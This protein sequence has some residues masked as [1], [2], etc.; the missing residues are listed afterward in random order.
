VHSSVTATAM[1]YRVTRTIPC[2]VV[3]F[4]PIIFPASPVAAGISDVSHVAGAAVDQREEVRL[5][6][7]V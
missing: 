6:I 5:E 1:F 3:D 7:K 4:T 2:H